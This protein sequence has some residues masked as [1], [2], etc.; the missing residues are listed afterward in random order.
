VRVVRQS[1]C[2]VF[3]RT[4]VLCTVQRATS[5]D[6]EQPVGCVRPPT[7]QELCTCAMGTEEEEGSAAVLA[8]NFPSAKFVIVLNRDLPGHTSSLR[9]PVL[10]AGSFSLKESVFCATPYRS[11]VKNEYPVHIG[12]QSAETAPAP[13]SFLYLVQCVVPQC[14]WPTPPPL[15]AWCHLPQAGVAEFCVVRAARRRRRPRPAEC[16]GTRL[17]HTPTRWR[18]TR[19]DPLRRLA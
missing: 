5:V 10:A 8:D 15:S 17:G 3:E 9:P 11:R 18:A 7:H 2:E 13:P 6:V 1:A 16:S 12:C 14:W 19:H 4:A